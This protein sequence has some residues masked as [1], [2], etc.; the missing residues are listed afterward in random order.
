MA[1]AWLRV[2]N[3]LAKGAVKIIFY[4]PSTVWNIVMFILLMVCIFF[5]LKLN[6]AYS[7]K[8]KDAREKRE[9]NEKTDS[10]ESKTKQLEAYKKAQVNVSG[11][12]D[13]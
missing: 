3:Y 12:M 6:K 11:V 1:F 2:F 7:K 8:L 4:K 9:Q 5:Y 10:L 13:K